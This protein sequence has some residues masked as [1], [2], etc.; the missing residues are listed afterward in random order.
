MRRP[1]RAPKART[2]GAAR[3]PGSAE[4]PLNSPFADL[5]K[6]WRLRPPPPPPPPP[7][8]PPPA[9]KKDDGPDLFERAMEG[10]RPLPRRARVDGPMPASKPRPRVSEE[11][12][13]LAELSDLVHGNAH[14]DVADTR[15]Y[16]EG[17]IVGLDPRVLRRLRRGDFAWQAHVDLHGMTAERARTAVLAFLQASVRAGFR[18]V[19]IVHGRGLNSKDHVPVLKERMKS[20]LARGAAARIVLAFTTAR[21]CDG[22]AGALYVLLRRDRSRR[23]IRVTEGAK[24]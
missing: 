20:W 3:L 5:G 19:L 9:A 14:F 23:P 17:A 15:E 10:V 16:V 13:A 7:P 21:P 1:R 12:E 22:G 11:A 8:A 24:S 2:D 4:S 6:Q 18:C